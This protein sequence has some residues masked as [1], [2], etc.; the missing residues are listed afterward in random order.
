MSIKIGN[1]NLTELI[2]SKAYEIA[3]GKYINDDSINDRDVNNGIIRN[4]NIKL[5]NKNWFSI[6]DIFLSNPNNPIN[7]NKIKT[8]KKKLIFK[9][10]G[11]WE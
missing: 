3:N 2:G 9:F 1:S 11:H 10:R 4:T 8:G 7:K 5:R 6:L